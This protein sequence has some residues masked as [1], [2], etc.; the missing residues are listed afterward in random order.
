MTGGILD[1]GGHLERLHRYLV[2]LAIF[3]QNVINI[4]NYIMYFLI[5]IIIHLFSHMIIHYI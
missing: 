3:D 2:I 1:E 5:I 4:I